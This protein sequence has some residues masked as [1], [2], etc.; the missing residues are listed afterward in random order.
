MGTLH[1]YSTKMENVEEPQQQA[2]EAAES[3]QEQATEQASAAFAEAKAGFE[4]SQTG[5]IA[6]VKEAIEKF[7]QK[8]KDL[9]QGLLAKCEGQ[10]PDEADL[11][12]IGYLAGLQAKYEEAIKAMDEAIHGSDSAD[13]FWDGQ[14]KTRRSR[15]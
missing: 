4:S 10:A 13:G 15:Q 14:R 11:Y 1:K 6:K 9:I 12:N 2:T 3:A 8:I 5:L 7:G